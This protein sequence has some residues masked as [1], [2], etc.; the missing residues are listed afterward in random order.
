LDEPVGRWVAAGIENIFFNL[1]GSEA[2]GTGL[3]MLHVKTLPKNS[4]AT[5]ATADRRAGIQPAGSRIEASRLSAT[6]CTLI[7]LKNQIMLTNA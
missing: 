2:G 7:D 6:V 3:E 1:W 5:G 4:L